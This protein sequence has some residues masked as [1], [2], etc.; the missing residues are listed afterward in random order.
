M[1]RPPWEQYT[2][3]LN[4]RPQEE[5]GRPAFIRFAKLAGADN[6]EIV[7]FASRFGPLQYEYDIVTRLLKGTK[8]FSEYLELLGHDALAARFKDSLNRARDAAFHEAFREILKKLESLQKEHVA[9][10]EESIAAKPLEEPLTWWRQEAQAMNSL[11]E[12]H[13]AIT[14]M[15]KGQHIK[16]TWAG[17]MAARW[18]GVLTPEDLL[19]AATEALVE[20]PRELSP[21]TPFCLLLRDKLDAKIEGRLQVEFSANKGWSFEPAPRNLREALYSQFVMTLTGGVHILTCRNVNCPNGARFIST[22]R[23]K[24]FCSDEC[25]W[26]TQK[27]RQRARK[28]EGG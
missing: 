1:F 23:G 8:A 24:N 4:P 9:P 19:I 5:N 12:L 27:R 22:R 25:R 16:S 2:L 20:S 26:A 3:P 18:A 28:K 10:L 6:E 21:E 15:N 14:Q 7:K 13:E 17:E 11:L